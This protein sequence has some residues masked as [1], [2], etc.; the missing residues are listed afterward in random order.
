MQVTNISDRK[1]T[2]L[3]ILLI[4]VVL[5]APFGPTIVVIDEGLT[6][7]EILCRIGNFP[8]PDVRSVIFTP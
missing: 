2:K 4:S 8:Y 7:M 1:L 3:T 5:P 6:S